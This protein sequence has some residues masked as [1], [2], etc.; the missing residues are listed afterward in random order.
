MAKT[1][2]VKSAKLFNTKYV[3]NLFKRDESSIQ[4][5]AKQKVL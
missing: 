2:E 5:L 1:E 4:K 3:A